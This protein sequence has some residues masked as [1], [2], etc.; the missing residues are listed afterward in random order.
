MK[1]GDWETIRG[2]HPLHMAHM[3]GSHVATATVGA[4]LKALKLPRKKV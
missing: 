2:S 4:Y 1:P 3:G